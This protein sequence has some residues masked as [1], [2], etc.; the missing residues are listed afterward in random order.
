VTT[1]RVATAAGVVELSEGGGYVLPHEHV[2][3]DIRPWWTGEGDPWSLDPPGVDLE[4]MLDEIVRMPEGTSRENM[5]L[6]DWYVSAKELRLARES[7]CQLFVD[8]TCEGLRPLH[9]L[10]VQAADLAEIGV[11]LSVGRYIGSSLDAEARRVGVD[12]LTDRWVRTT[13]EGFNK[14]RPG[15]IGE[16]GT[17]ATIEDVEMVSLQ[18]AAQAQQASGL[19][20]N[21]HLH[22][23][24]RQAITVLDTLE[25]AGADCSRVALSHCDG[26]FDRDF[27]L[28][29]L[30]RGCYVEFDQFGTTPDQLFEGCPMPSDAERI[31]MIVDLCER[32]YAQQLLLSQDICHRHSLTR[33]GGTGYAH[34]AVTVLPELRHRLGTGVTDQVVSS[35]PL[36]LL[37]LGE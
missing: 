13:L 9:D 36:R 34:L 3:V 31:D 32:G 26:E 7:G 14:V 35:N 21:V 19:P 22:P 24:G 18:A 25:Q 23:F 10:V 33:Y 4:H 20:I 5:V 15:I 37:S 11:V 28:R 29:I 30:D 16:I 6:C 27:L 8:L 1:Y 12:E 17:S 2:I